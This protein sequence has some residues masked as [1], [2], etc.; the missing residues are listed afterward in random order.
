MCVVNYFDGKE[1]KYLKFL[2]NK[3]IYVIMHNYSIVSAYRLK[4]N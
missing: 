3:K 1:M 2:F 4:N